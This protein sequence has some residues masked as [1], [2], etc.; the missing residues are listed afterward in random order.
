M[1][2][3]TIPVTPDVEYRGKV[4]GH[5]PDTSWKAAKRQTRGNTAR[6]QDHL[7]NLLVRYGPMTD[8]ELWSRYVKQSSRSPVRYRWASP[9]SVRTRRHELGVAGRVRDLLEERP[10]A[11]GFPSALREAIQ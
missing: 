4:R 3:N 8:D 6:L 11:L 7:W 5:D 10:S 9:A 2:E 1:P